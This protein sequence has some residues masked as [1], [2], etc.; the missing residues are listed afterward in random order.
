MM[1]K[2]AF[3]MAVESVKVMLH[4]VEQNERDVLHWKAPR[5]RKLESSEK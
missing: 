5:P 4:V 2:H 3:A 1:W